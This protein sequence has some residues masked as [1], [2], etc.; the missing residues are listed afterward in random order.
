MQDGVPVHCTTEAKNFL[1]EKF[2]GRV[3]SRFIDNACPANSLELIPLDSYFLA[4]A[5]RTVYKTK[6]S[7][8][9]EI[10]NIVNSSHLR[11]AKK[12]CRL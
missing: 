11:L 1:A 5:Q 2:R 9:A 4:V 8:V 7:T 3:I 6:P 10:I 12:C